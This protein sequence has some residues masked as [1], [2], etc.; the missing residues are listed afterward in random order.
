MKKLFLFFISIFCF[1]T[2][3]QTGMALIAFA[4]MQG[5]KIPKILNPGQKVTLSKYR[6]TKLTSQDPSIFTIENNKDGTHTLIAHQPGTTTITSTH[7]NS[8]SPQKPVGSITVSYPNL[9]SIPEKVTVGTI[10]YV[11]QN[12]HNTDIWQTSTNHDTGDVKIKTVR[13][14]N[15]KHAT[16]IKALNAGPVT[17]QNT[18]GTQKTIIIEKQ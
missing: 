18:G 14:A 6:H 4:A 15:N 8:T 2:T 7:K 3:T 13:L 5:N 17:L 1:Y 11:A 10:L 12:T 16:H 9:T